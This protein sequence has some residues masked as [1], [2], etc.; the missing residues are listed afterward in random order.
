[1]ESFSSGAY[2]DNLEEFS[3]RVQSSKHCTVHFCVNQKLDHDTWLW[4]FYGGWMVA[5]LVVVENMVE[6]L[7]KREKKERNPKA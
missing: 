7:A 5:I 1:M 4:G 2:L 3:K 6:E